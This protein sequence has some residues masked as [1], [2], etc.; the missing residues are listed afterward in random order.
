[1]RTIFLLDTT[2]QTE[3]TQC[4]DQ[5]AKNPRALVDLSR[6]MERGSNFTPNDSLEAVRCYPCL[7]F[8]FKQRAIAEQGASRQRP[9]TIEKDRTGIVATMKE[10]GRV[11]DKT[12]LGDYQAIIAPLDSSRSQGK[13]LIAN[14]SVISL[15]LSIRTSNVLQR[16]GILC[17]ADLAGYQFEDLHG[18]KNL[19]S[20]SINEIADCLE[21]LGL[22]LPFF[23]KD[24]DA[25]NKED[26]D[27]TSPTV[28]PQ[29]R[30]R[31]LGLRHNIIIALEEAGIIYVSDLHTL[32]EQDLL[33]IKG[34]DTL[35]FLQLREALS[36][37]G[38]SVWDN[39]K[40]NNQTG[41][42]SRE[43]LL[44]L[45]I[46][47]LREWA[48][49]RGFEITIGDILR[50]EDEELPDDVRSA[51]GGVTSMILNQESCIRENK[52]TLLDDL[53]S[54]LDPRQLSVLDRRRWSLQPDTLTEIGSDL[55]IARE[56]ARKLQEKGNREVAK[57][58]SN[59][60]RLRWF[61][62]EV[63]YRVG[64]LTTKD[65]LNKIIMEYGVESNSMRWQMLADLAGPYKIVYDNFAELN[66]GNYLSKLITEINRKVETHSQ[67]PHEDL[68]HILSEFDLIRDDIAVDLCERIIG[69]RM[70]GS[71]WYPWK[72]SI[73]DKAFVILRVEG[74]PMTADEINLGISEG[75]SQRSLTNRMASDERFIRSSKTQWSLSEW[76]H[77]EYTGIADELYRRIEAAGGV[78]SIQLLVEDLVKTYGVA[79][80]SVRMYLS[81]P[82]FIVEGDR[83]RRRVDFSMLVFESP[84]RTATG[85]YRFGPVVRYEVKIT[86]DIL[87]GSGQAI[88]VG[89]AIALGVT[90]GT[91][92]TFIS[93]DGT[94][95]YVGWREWSTSGPD[96]GS[97]RRFAEAVNA[98]EGD[99][100][101]ISFNTEDET[102]EV[103]HEDS[104][105]D[106]QEV[107]KKIVE[108]DDNHDINAL[109]AQSI[110]VKRSEVKSVLR[111]R[112][113][114]RVASMLPTIES[115]GVDLEVVIDEL[116]GE[117]L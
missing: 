62:H 40:E 117:L 61:L 12:L 36:Q 65:R 115:G 70:I 18:L 87:R 80:S 110:E 50:L 20:T 44:Q 55:S 11:L 9:E 90:P 107:L 95:L 73:T 83:V 30:L 1:M 100:I 69:L 54:F 21:Q 58:L 10:S 105:L 106:S 52:C 16:N 15:G 102:L 33:A 66:G 42:R 108:T 98:C 103:Q 114:E 91:K 57:Y 41:T 48:A 111:E 64:V 86:A 13:L 76:G 8:A 116:I 25:F 94:K 45:N 53:R 6:I 113:D 38:V 112:G 78:S 28:L 51:R 97:M 7:C 46:E 81:T 37:K 85:T 43:S 71:T 56:G 14:H 67:L 29:K 17:L 92:R 79:E 32:T 24:I 59:N 49:W 89:T 4:L 75:H 109:I 19:G 99:Y 96:I 31:E 101:I 63:R 93:R 34:F 88:P 39:I 82:A 26:Q 35:S 60:K 23:A 2:S 22:T 47:T 74:K 68:I 3:I 77:E 84:L 104:S 72:G 27:S 5:L